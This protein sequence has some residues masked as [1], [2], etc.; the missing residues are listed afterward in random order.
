MGGAGQEF[1]GSIGY[2]AQRGGPGSE[3]T[4]A[5][6]DQAQDRD[7]AVFFVFRKRITS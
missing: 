6:R 1:K 4:A 7:C 3:R 5:A 2:I